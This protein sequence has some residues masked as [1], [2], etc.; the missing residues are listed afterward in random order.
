MW[1]AK[2]ISYIVTFLISMYITPCFVH[3]SLPIT[4]DSRIKTLIY[5]PNEVFKLKF[6]YNYQ[7]YIEFPPDEKLKIITVGD[8]FPWHIKQ[9]GSRLFIKPKQKGVST[10]MSIITNKRAY[11]FELYASNKDYNIIDEDLIYVA[12][13]F[14]PDSTYDFLQSVRIK[15]PIKNIPIIEAPKTKDSIK[16]N[17]TSDDKTTKPEK[18]ILS[19]LKSISEKSNKE[20]I[21][22]L[23]KKHNL[24]FNYSL[25]GP[26]S[27]I[28][29]SKIFDNGERTFF[30]FPSKSLPDIFYVNIDGTETPAKYF[31]EHGLVV[32]EKVAWQFTL[33]NNTD[34][35]CVFN[36]EKIYF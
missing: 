3:A 24:N 12:K 19:D 20:N 10:N 15:R 18:S 26:N 13:F 28:T 31:V 2:K 16:L 27:N 36:E 8:K 25:V 33:R 23:S 7:S 35:I 9:S 22:N 4:T 14:Y 32:V 34:L 6:H 29:P 11:H 21:F 5:S 17:T 1:Y 30:E